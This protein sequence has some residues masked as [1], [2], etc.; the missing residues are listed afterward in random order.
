MPRVIVPCV[1]SQISDN[2]GQYRIILEWRR[3]GGGGGGGGWGGGGGGVMSKVVNLS[4]HVSVSYYL[5]GCLC[6][7]N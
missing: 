1:I 3:G 6:P 7:A 2:V 5:L 4:V